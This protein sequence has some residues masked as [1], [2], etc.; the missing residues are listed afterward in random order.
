MDNLENCTSLCSV[1]HAVQIQGLAS[2]EEW[3]VKTRDNVDI[4]NEVGV[5]TW[6]PV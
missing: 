1:L 3:A 5:R 4:S 6:P 2:C